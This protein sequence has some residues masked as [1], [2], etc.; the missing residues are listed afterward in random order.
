M[1]I[2][3]S[4]FIILEGEYF[5]FSIGYFCSTMLKDC[6]VISAC[7]SIDAIIKH[8]IHLAF[9]KIFPKKRF[10]AS[11]KITISKKG[12]VKSYGKSIFIKTYKLTIR[13][14]SCL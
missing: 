3:L 4:F 10:D 5:T 7:I 6:E 1:Q 9:K 14:I 12:A 11:S 13:N 2:V 8:Q